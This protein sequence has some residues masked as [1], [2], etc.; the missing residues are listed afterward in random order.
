MSNKEKALGDFI[1]D[2]ETD[3]LIEV[4]HHFVS[5]VL[6]EKSTMELLLE[7][8][9][10]PM[11]KMQELADKLGIPCKRALLV[12]RRLIRRMQY[13]ERERSKKIKSF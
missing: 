2:I 9:E 10:E 1:P 5:E 6:R 7:L 13:Y 12:Q 8:D 3:E 11:H 4:R